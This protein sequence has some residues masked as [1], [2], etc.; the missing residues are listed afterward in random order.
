[1]TQKTVGQE[2][3][4]RLL[5]AWEEEHRPRPRPK[6]EVVGESEVQPKEVR[7]GLAR[8]VGEVL[9]K[10][11]PEMPKDARFANVVRIDAERLYWEA[12][13]RAFEP[14]RGVLVR[15]EYNPFVRFDDE[16]A[17]CHREKRDD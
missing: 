2:L 3:A 9:K 4:E 5:A 1:M 17:E 6:L 8:P 10:L 13:R 15:F 12:T 7:V 14:K 11:D 16:I